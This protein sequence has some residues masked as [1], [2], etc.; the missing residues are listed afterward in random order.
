[1]ARESRAKRRENRTWTRGDQWLFR[2]DV[3]SGVLL[4]AAATVESFW[5]SLMPR[6]TVHQA[7]VSGASAAT[8]FAAGS[9]AYGWGKTLAR[10]EGLPRVAALGANAAVAAGVLAAVRDHPGAHLWRPTAR[11]GAEAVLAGSIA[12][13]AVELVRTSPRPVR[14]GA[15]LGAGAAAAGGVR[16]TFA[17]RAQLEHRDEYDGP[18]PKALPAVAQSVSV[19][20]A[21]A[22]VVNGF[23][24]SGEAFARLLHRRIGVPETPARIAGFLGASATWAAV[25]VAFADTF[26]K[27]MELYNRV[28]DP[29]YEDP[30]TTPACSAG[31]G[32][33]LGYARTGREGRRFIAD[34]PSADDIAAVTGQA[35]VAEPVR[36]YVGFDHARHAEERVALALAELERTGAYDRSVLI[37]GCPPGNGWV[38]TIPLEVADYLL[39]GDSAGVTIQYERLPSLLSI[40]RARDGGRHLKLLLEGIRD[41]LAD[42]PADRRPRVMVYGESLGAWA[43]QDA[44]LH[45]GTGALDELGVDRALWVG[46]PFYSGWLRE[47]HA[48]GGPIEDGT[49]IEI[50]G[51][52][53]LDALDDEARG[54]IRTVLLSHDNDPVRLINVDL[55]VREPDWLAT[56]HRR[57]AVPREQHFMPMITGYQTILD[58][59]NATNPVPGVFRATGHDYRSD[60][61]AVTVAAYGL[62]VPSAEV[63]DRLMT[64]L[65]ADEAAR[66]ARFRLPSPE[67]G[68]GDAEVSAAVNAGEADGGRR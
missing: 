56:E 4:G 26:V 16:V 51:I 47:A 10:Q 32:S 20:A 14:A 63:A 46:T 30:P 23:R 1:M 54:R 5:P 28:L 29:G 38:N 17:I 7:A 53:Q 44:F 49:A 65:Q 50:D 3:W 6:S 2:P 12:A 27:G 24:F 64:K 58:T 43:G 60:L 40:Q 42:R 18:P 25:G 68:D 11:A 59:V 66:A 37:V 35:A 13:T 8:G 45:G 36:I 39:L 22:A 41:A 57:P 52:E 21:L 19:A 9:A 62:P 33:P 48:P 31:P 34:R 15:I 67:A 61:P 55:L